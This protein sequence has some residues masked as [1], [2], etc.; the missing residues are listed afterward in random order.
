MYNL[1]SYACIV[2]RYAIQLIYELQINL[3]L[4]LSLCVCNH[5]RWRQW[6]CWQWRCWRWRWHRPKRLTKAR[7]WTPASSCVRVASGSASECRPASTGITSAQCWR[8][9]ASA[10]ATA[11]NSDGSA[12]ENDSPARANASRRRASNRLLLLLQRPQN[13]DTFH[14]KMAIIRASHTVEIAHH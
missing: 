1:G 4:F 2:L 12:N 8:R 11:T 13:R 7:R 6:R 3:F 10:A 5:W 14:A 9:S